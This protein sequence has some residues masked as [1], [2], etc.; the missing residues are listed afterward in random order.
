MN[1]TGGN[2]T[3]HML[4]DSTVQNEIFQRIELGYGQG[5]IFTVKK[6]NM[7]DILE[8]TNITQVKNLK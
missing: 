3:F 6:S 1:I 7:L 2:A 5:D 4:G 8:L